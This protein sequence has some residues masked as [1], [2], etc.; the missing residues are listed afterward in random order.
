MAIDEAIL[1]AAGHGEV[2]PTLR[3]YSWQPACL[4]LGYAQPFADADQAALERF[5]WQ[6]VRRPTGGRA[7]LHTDELTYSV[8]GPQ[9]EPRLAGSVLESY[10][11]AGGG[12]VGSAARAR[13]SPLKPK[14]NRCRLACRPYGS[15]Q[16]RSKPGVF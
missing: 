8:S 5:G 2:P 1:E 14:K 3:L 9:S 4:S 16:D 11:V 7:I 15:N 12:A 13:I 10:R 6:I